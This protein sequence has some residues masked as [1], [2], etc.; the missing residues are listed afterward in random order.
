ML[1]ARSIIQ[2]IYI[3]LY[4][5]CAK[6]KQS[7]PQSTA[8]SKKLSIVPQMSG[9]QHEVKLPRKKSPLPPPVLSATSSALPA[10]GGNVDDLPPKK[11]STE[12]LRS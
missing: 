1:S 8:I 12:T 10:S 5:S 11:L 9:G 3:Y 7:I 4:L 2:R 6:K